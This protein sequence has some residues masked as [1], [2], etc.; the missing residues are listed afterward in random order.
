M[1]DFALYS[2]GGR[3]IP[4]ITSDTFEQPIPRWGGLLKPKVILG[5]P[6]A[7]ALVP[8]VNVGNCWPFAGAKGQLGIKLARR[9]HVSDITIEHAAREVSFDMAAAPRDIE[10][11]SCP[12]P[13]LTPVSRA[14][15]HPL[16]SLASLGPRRG[17]GQLRQGRRVPGR[18]RRRAADVVAA[19]V[20]GLHPARQPVVRHRLASPRPD[21]H[22]PARHPGP[23]RRRR[24]RRRPHRQQLRRGLH[25]PLPRAYPSCRPGSRPP[26]KTLTLSAPP[27]LATAQVR[28]HGEAAPDPVYEP[29]T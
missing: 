16:L 6:P 1:T 4:S 22:R 15:R 14:N 8:D 21:V 28:V 23:G 2:A 25:V 13:C 3:V 29:S 27:L 20:A 18:S 24:H 19:A 26:P 17:P 7:T 11:A 5:R 9:V 12:S 10:G